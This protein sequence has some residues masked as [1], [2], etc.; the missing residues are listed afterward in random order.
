MEKM[1]Q[2]LWAV[3]AA[4]V[5]AA[6]ATLVVAVPSHMSLA[7]FGWANAAVVAVIAIVGAS[8]RAG[9]PTRSIAHVLYDTEQQRERVR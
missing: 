1:N 6:I 2:Y 7:T 9:G 8:L 3:A 4:W 5:A